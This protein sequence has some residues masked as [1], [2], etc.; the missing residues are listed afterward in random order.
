MLKKGNNEAFSFYHLSQNFNFNDFQFQASS[1][2][3]KACNW[4]QLYLNFILQNNQ[5]IQLRIAF[6]IHFV[7]QSGNNLPK[8]FH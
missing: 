1:L 3:I 2:L 6:V 7:K 4:L 8:V 5:P